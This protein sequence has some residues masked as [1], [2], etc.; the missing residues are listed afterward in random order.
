MK[1]LARLLPGLLMLLWLAPGLAVAPQASQAWIRVLPGD[2]P[3]AGYLELENRGAR[4]LTLTG[5]RSPAFRQIEIHQSLDESG[6]A[7]MLML[8]RVDIPP[9]ERLVFA[10]GGYHLMLFGRTQTLRP[11]DNVSV[12][13]EFGD[14][15]RLVVP[16]ALREATGR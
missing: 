15:S 4:T 3:L 14:G 16:F 13:L 7:R 8:E 10:P 12:T 6:V 1:A 5:A 11:G 9:G 2:L